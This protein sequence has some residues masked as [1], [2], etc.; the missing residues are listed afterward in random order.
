VRKIRKGDNV[1]VINAE[2]VRFTGKKLTQKVYYRHT[3]YA[4]G[5][6]E[7][8]GQTDQSGMSM[9]TI[10]GSEYPGVN[11]GLYRVEI[12]GKGNDGKPLAAKYNSQSSLAKISFSQDC[13][14]PTSR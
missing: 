2:K 9:V 4:G 10:P 8:S 5:I 3:G 1:I 7:A 6:K 14:S 12:S 11:C 13:S